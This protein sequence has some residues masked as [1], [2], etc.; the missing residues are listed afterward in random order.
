MFQTKV[1]EKNKT[2]V[3]CSIY[4]YIYIY[5]H[6]CLC[7]CVCVCVC[8]LESAAVYEAMWKNTVEADMP[9]MTACVILRIKYTI[10]VLDN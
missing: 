10:C 3:L 5:I 4:I 8:V 9:Q 2:N 1:V 7:V 6:I